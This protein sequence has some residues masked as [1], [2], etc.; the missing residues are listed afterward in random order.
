MRAKPMPEA[1]ILT[2]RVD[3][4]I[5]I[6]DDIIVMVVAI[7][8]AKVRLGVQAPSAW[9]EPAPSGVAIDRQEL[10]ERKI[11]DGVRADGRI[12]NRG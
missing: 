7:H 6:G 3:E 5:L 1:L 4:N 9:A 11:R 10:P 8:G 12:D 2:R